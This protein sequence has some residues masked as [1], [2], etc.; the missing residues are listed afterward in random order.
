[1]IKFFR[2][3]VNIFKRIKSYLIVDESYL[4][5][6]LNLNAELDVAPKTF[7]IIVKQTNPLFPL[8]TLGIIVLTDNESV[9][10]LCKKHF[11]PRTLI[12]LPYSSTREDIEKE[13]SKKFSYKELYNCY[14]NYGMSKMFK[15]FRVR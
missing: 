9:I 10:E 6:N 2:K 15:I 1:M 11:V 14:Y 12:I 4:I 5:R 7:E 8:H 13:I 3:L